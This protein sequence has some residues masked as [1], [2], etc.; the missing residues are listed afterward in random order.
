MQSQEITTFL[1]QIKNFESILNSLEVEVKRA[2]PLVKDRETLNL[3]SN[4]LSEISK[5]RAG[6]A[7]LKRLMKLL[8]K[9]GNILP[10]TR[11]VSNGR[12]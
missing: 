6:C 8:D 9:L 4:V 11:G 5:S 7:S 1:G 10:K 12:R 3:F 2:I